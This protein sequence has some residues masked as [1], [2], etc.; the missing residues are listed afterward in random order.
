MASAEDGKNT[1][2]QMQYVFIGIIAF[3]STSLLI[4][5]I[6]LLTIGYMNPFGTVGLGILGGGCILYFST[7]LFFCMSSIWVKN[8]YYTDKTDFGDKQVGAPREDISLLKPAS[9]VTLP[10]NLEI[11]SMSIP[12]DNNNPVPLYSVSTVYSSVSSCSSPVPEKIMLY[13]WHGDDSDVFTASLTT[14]QDS[15][16]KSQEKPQINQGSTEL[17]SCESTGWN[18]VYMEK[19][20]TED[21]A[22]HHNNGKSIPDIPRQ[23]RPLVMDT[24][25][26][27]TP[28][29]SCNPH[30]NG[31]KQ[32][33]KSYLDIQ[34]KTT[35]EN[36]TSTNAQI[37]K[38]L[39]G[40][41]TSVTP[42]KYHHH[43]ADRSKKPE[44]G[45]GTN[46]LQM[47][48]N[49]SHEVEP[50]LAN[51]GVHFGQQNIQTSNGHGALTAKGDASIQAATKENK[52]TFQGTTSKGLYTALAASAESDKKH[53]SSEA[54]SHDR[55][56][57]PLQYLLPKSQPD[58]SAKTPISSQMTATRDPSQEVRI[59]K[60][61]AKPGTRMGY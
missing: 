3:V 40:V 37:G 24:A 1:G 42:S 43:L 49:S 51:R 48:K 21:I 18:K 61:Q 59:V 22:I 44:E 53:K 23:R 58:H 39:P 34:M 28:A 57:I 15:H 14:M 30:E 31:D 16:I 27:I 12:V 2:M 10:A 6:V 17:A 33:V 7:L 38:T 54:F 56:A 55:T 41:P 45:K 50:A 35:K 60:K 19:R 26:G 9:N 36:N 11:R 25:E 20:H 47:L 52:Q 29:H 46:H 13:N 4:A 5:S 8:K 32:L